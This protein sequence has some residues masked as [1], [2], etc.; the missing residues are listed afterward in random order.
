LG[1]NL[2]DVVFENSR[3]VSIYDGFDR[4]R[5]DLEN[6]VSLIREFRAR[7]ILDIGCGTGC[8]ASILAKEGFDVIGVEPAKAS[9]EY[10][11]KKPHAEK[12]RWILGDATTLPPLAVD[13]AVMTGNVAQVFLDDDSWAK[14]LV[15][16]RRVLKKDG[17]FVFEVRDPAQKAWLQ[18]TRENTYQRVNFP[19]VG[20]VEC[21]C[22]VTRIQGDLVSFRWTFVFE[23]DGAVLESDSTLR[24]RE[25]RAIENSL[26]QAGFFVKEVRDAPDRPGKEFVFVTSL[27]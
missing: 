11:Q 2:P 18:W 26:Q 21:W 3:L 17:H 13:L 27:R 16:I 4:Q 15:G 12:V 22:D 1:T 7:S 10:A 14:T 19:E 25:R 9:L 24:F 5:V 23:S 6:Y 8:L 20:N